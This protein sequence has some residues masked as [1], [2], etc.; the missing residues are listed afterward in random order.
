MSFSA[1]HRAGA[2]IG[3]LHQRQHSAG[4]LKGVAFRPFV[5]PID[6]GRRLR[7]PI[8][9]L[10]LQGITRGCDKFV[11]QEIIDKCVGP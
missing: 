9:S 3:R 10:K 1:L 6:G 2:T 4:S 7:V 8:A 11:I 5:N